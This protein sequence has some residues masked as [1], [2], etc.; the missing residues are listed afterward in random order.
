ME[1]KKAAVEKELIIHDN[2]ETLCVTCHNENSPAFK[3]FNFKEMWAKI[4]HSV[5]KK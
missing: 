3:G 4:E 5:P 2:I 1:D